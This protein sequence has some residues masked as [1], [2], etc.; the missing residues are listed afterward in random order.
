[1]IPRSRTADGARRG[2]RSLVVNLP[3]RAGVDRTSP[4]PVGQRPLSRSGLKGLLSCRGR[5]PPCGRRSIAVLVDQPGGVRRRQW[6]YTSGGPR[7]GS[8]PP[9]AVASPLATSG[10]RPF[11]R[12]RIRAGVG[13]GEEGVEGL[14]DRVGEHEGGV[15]IATPTRMAVVRAA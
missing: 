6:R 1:M 8:S 4:G 5:G 2:D 10:P 3:R 14:V 7:R 12:S 9:G 13:V 11:L 15:T